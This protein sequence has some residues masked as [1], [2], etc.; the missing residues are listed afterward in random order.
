[1]LHVGYPEYSVELKLVLVEEEEEHGEVLSDVKLARLAQE[2]KGAV[3]EEGAGVVL[4]ESGFL[5]VKE[6]RPLRGAQAV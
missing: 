3:D 4:E 5:K 6:F 2:D 1:M